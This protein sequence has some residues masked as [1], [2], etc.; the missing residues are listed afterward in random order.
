MTFT[1][2]TPENLEMSRL[3]MSVVSAAMGGGQGGGSN[4]LVR[5]IYQD[6]P[7]SFSTYLLT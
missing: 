6:K 4:S 7:E 3:V 2:I 5:N 1:T